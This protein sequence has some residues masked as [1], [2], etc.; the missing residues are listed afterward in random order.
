MRARGRARLAMTSHYKARGPS[1]AMRRSRSSATE[2]PNW[3][4]WVSGALLG[5][6][7]VFGGGG[8]PSP[9]AELVVEMAALAA[10]VV[11]AW[12][13]GKDRGHSL[14]EIDRPLLILAALFVAIPVLQLV[15]LPPAI[16]HNLPGREIEV[17]ALA[18]VDRNTAWMPLSES[19][20]HTL[21]SLL[22]LI[23]PI[24][25]LVMVSRL[26][27]R[28]RLKLVGLLAVLGLV[29]AVIGVF[30]HRVVR[31]FTVAP[32]DCPIQAIDIQKAAS[33]SGNVENGWIDNIRIAPL[34]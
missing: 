23:P 12:R 31:T 16:W 13:A 26:R 33:L 34:G 11:W 29:A 1:R 15:P 32:Q 24:V 22:S 7:I 30:Q 21:A 14:A 20:P 8:T 28:E 17:Q 18:L 19:P 5:I 4:L 6:A 25:M 3:R 9:G 27:E 2:K 10:I